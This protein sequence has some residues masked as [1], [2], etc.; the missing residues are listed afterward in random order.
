VKEGSSSI[1]VDAHH[2][3]WDPSRRDYPWMTGPAAALR[4]PYTVD[5]LRAETEAVGVHRTVLVQ[6]V[7][8]VAETEEF[9]AVAAD[10][11]GLIAGVIGWVDLTAPDV[12]DTLARLRAAPGGHLLVGIRHQAHD[13]PDPD[14]LARPDVLRGLSTLAD[15]GLVYDLL[16][17]TR[18]LPA[19]LRAARAVDTLRFVVDHAA[20]PDIAGG[21]VEPWATRLRG[22][23]ALPNVACKL[24]GLVTEAAWSTWTVRDL[25]PYFDRILPLFGTDRLIFGSDWPVCTL[26]ATY[27]EV[28]HAARSCLSDLS[29]G[30]VAA[31]FGGVATSMYGLLATGRSG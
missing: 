17:R 31:V 5:D 11:G 7:S 18:E 21:V 24:S 9:L 6:T 19:S 4:I 16:V 8:E 3:L 10:S 13:E 27:G 14:W 30:E 25:R 22:L 23:A 26:A 28:F 29:A 20:K 2:H 15:H 12:A 1:I